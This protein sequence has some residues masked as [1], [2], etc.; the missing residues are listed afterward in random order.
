MVLGSD[1][2]ERFSFREIGLNSIVIPPLV[3]VLGRGC[4]HE[5]KSFESVI[6]ASAF[7]GSWPKRTV[8]PCNVTFIGTSAC[9]GAHLDLISIS[10]HNRTFCLH[11]LVLEALNRS[12]IYDP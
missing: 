2:F 9:D 3:V 6:E 12:M 7:E 10:R 11:E 4:F 5:C 1:R 8:I